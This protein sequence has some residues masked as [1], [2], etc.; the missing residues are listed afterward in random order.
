[1]TARSILVGMVLMAVGCSG[2]IMTDDEVIATTK[3]CKDAG[4]DIDYVYS[5][6][7]VIG[8]RQGIQRV[9]CVPPREK[10]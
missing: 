1:M 8:F 6:A 10:P 7:G 9:Y 2:K 4:M 5:V 3:K